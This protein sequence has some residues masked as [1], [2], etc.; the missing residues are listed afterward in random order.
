MA[1]MTYPQANFKEKA[2]MNTLASSFRSYAAS[3][4]WVAPALLLSFT[5]FATTAQAQSLG[6]EGPTGIFVTPLASVADSPANGL[7]KPAVAYHF[8][9]GGPVI[10]DFSTVSTTVGFAKRFEMGYTSE[11]HGGGSDA[12]SPLWNSDFSIVHGK[13]NIL[14]SKT[15]GAISVGGIY[16]FNDQF[17]PNL[18]NALLGDR[19]STR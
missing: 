7:G 10:G 1:G 6:Y 18:S 15:I 17:G 12:L 14:S 16:R 19:K 3:M 11:I 13:A 2:R 8:L 5:A 9:A 4:K